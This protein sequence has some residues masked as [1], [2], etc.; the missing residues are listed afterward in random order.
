MDLTNVL[1]LKDQVAGGKHSH[2]QLDAK[3]DESNQNNFLKIVLGE[4]QNVSTI[5]TESR[6]LSMGHEP[7]R[8]KSGGE[9]ADDSEVA[10]NKGGKNDINDSSHASSKQS[11]YN[12]GWCS[13]PDQALSGVILAHQ[14]LSSKDSTS[15]L[16]DGDSGSTGS[17]GVGEISCLVHGCAVQPSSTNQVSNKVSGGVFESRDLKQEASIEHSHDGYQE[18]DLLNHGDRSDIKISDA[19]IERNGFKNSMNFFHSS[20]NR[21]EDSINQHHTINPTIQR[22]LDKSLNTDTLPHLK[23]GEEVILG[24]FGVSTKDFLNGEFAPIASVRN[25]VSITKFNSFLI[26]EIQTAKELGILKKEMTVNIRPSLIGDVSITIANS[27]NGCLV[28]LVTSSQAATNYLSLLKRD[29]EKT[30][31]VKISIGS[32][33]VDSKGNLSVVNFKQNKNQEKH[34][35]M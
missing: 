35:D 4:V 16:H 20:L 33:M 29:I 32:T 22:F 34:K 26:D 12:D 23:D 17:K 9:K 13:I 31:N 3:R 30:S 10:E 8:S 28:S 5:R 1:I 15:E 27:V 19:E 24:G 18:D 11:T 14:N 21:N 25:T 6:S 7:S 2:K